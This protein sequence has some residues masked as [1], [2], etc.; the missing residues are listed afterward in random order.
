MT[1]SAKKITAITRRRHEFFVLRRRLRFQLFCEQCNAEREFVAL[2][3]AVWFSRLTTREIVR[4]AEN[5]EIHF[6]ESLGGHLFICE[7]SI[8]EKISI[9]LAQLKQLQD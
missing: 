7:K 3:D 6:L 2:D 1:I 4:Q 5:R 9:Q 8:S